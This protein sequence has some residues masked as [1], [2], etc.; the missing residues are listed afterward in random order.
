ML[1]YKIQFENAMNFVS[2]QTKWLY[3]Q[4]KS[5]KTWPVWYGISIIQ[6]MSR[7]LVKFYLSLLWFFHLYCSEEIKRLPIIPLIVKRKYRREPTSKHMFEAKLNKPDF[8]WVWS[9][10]WS[11]SHTAQQNELHLLKT[12]INV[13]LTSVVQLHYK[14]SSQIL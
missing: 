14:K 9:F 7:I 11:F 3:I 2:K 5:T 4:I 6:N 8:I 13:L 12:Y 10:G 1:V